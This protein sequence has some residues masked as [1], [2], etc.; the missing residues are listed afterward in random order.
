[1]TFLFYKVMRWEYKEL[2]IY[3]NKTP[4]LIMCLTVTFEQCPLLT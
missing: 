3:E 2:E 4:N 1:M